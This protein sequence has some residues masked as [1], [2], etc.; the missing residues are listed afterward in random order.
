MAG[1]TIYALATALG[2]AGVAII[3]VSG[4]AVGVVASGICGGLP[5]P[6]HASLRKLRGR[7]GDHIDEALVLYFERGHS[8]TG[9]AVLELHLHG[10][11]AIIERVL[12]ELRGFEGVRAA[13]AGEFTRRAFENGKL[14]LVQVEGL[15]DLI[16][17]ETEGQRRLAQDVYDG[18]LSAEFEGIRSELLAGLAWVEASIDFAEE[19]VPDDL[20]E[21]VRSSVLA[22]RDRVERL[23]SGAQAARQLVSGYEVAIV[24]PPNAGKSTLLN[25]IVRREAAIVSDTPGTTRDVI[26]ARVTLGG[27]LV[28]FLD[29]AGLHESEDAIERE[30]ISRA[31][32]RAEDADLRIFLHRGEGV[33]AP[34]LVRPNDLVRESYGDLRDVA[35]LLSGKTGAG[36]EA[37]LG[38]VTVA[39]SKKA[40]RAG[41][42][43]SERQE[44][45]LRV[46]GEGLEACLV[47]LTEEA[48]A[49]IVSYELRGAVSSLEAILGRIDVEDV[50]GEIF[51]SF[52]I[53]K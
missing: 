12:E 42:M 1:D 23:L 15:G 39:L 27:L 29:T 45:L 2:R 14:D 37:L 11:L 5:S 4:P 25:A 20:S 49:E 24:G 6:R 16:E 34:E 43:S 35:G 3:R 47:A 44:G 33:S 48:P 52:C 41:L 50:L 26:E 22:A 13:I 18:K 46:C 31:R 7:A 40:E 8:F 21:S 32:R 9:E 38:E 17:A 28:T 53:G 36:V 10:S 19:E 30:G 51:S